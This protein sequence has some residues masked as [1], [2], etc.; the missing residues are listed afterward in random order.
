MLTAPPLSVKHE[1]PPLLTLHLEGTG[2]CHALRLGLRPHGVAEVDRPGRPLGLRPARNRLDLAPLRSVSVPALPRLGEEL[3]ELREDVLA[4]DEDV[5]RVPVGPLDRADERLGRGADP[6]G[7]LRP[8]PLQVDDRPVG[9]EEGL[10]AS[11]GPPVAASGEG[12]GEL[13]KGGFLTDPVVEGPEDVLPQADELLLPGLCE[14]KLECPA[15]APPGTA[16]TGASCT[17]S[18]RAAGRG[19]TAWGALSPR[20]NRPETTL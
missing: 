9:G 18:G 7:P 2:A 11:D 1:L 19:P 16:S 20:V 10:V 6:R 8:G 5:S 12:R 4:R 14:G 3:S 17:S 13:L 15:A